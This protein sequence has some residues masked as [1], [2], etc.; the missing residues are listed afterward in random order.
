MSGFTANFARL[1]YNLHYFYRIFLDAL[2]WSICSSTLVRAHK[3]Y[4]QRTSTAYTA[5]NGSPAAVRK[6]NWTLSSPLKLYSKTQSCA[7]FWIV[8]LHIPDMPKNPEIISHPSKIL[9][10]PCDRY[11]TNQTTT[12]LCRPNKLFL[13]YGDRLYNKNH[14]LASPLA[15]HTL[16]ISTLSSPRYWSVRFTLR[17]TDSP[18]FQS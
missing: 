1:G 2:V 9:S 5:N 6:C 16:F 13:K 4:S 3:E 11:C 7:A 14:V 17:I 15:S 10:F 8:L 12:V 18:L